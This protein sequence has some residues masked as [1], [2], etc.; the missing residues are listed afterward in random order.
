MSQRMTLGAKLTAGFGAMMLLTLAVSVGAITVISQLGGDMDYA[1][2][3]AGKRNSLAWQM[4]YA[5]TRAMAAERGILLR[6]IV[7]QTAAVDRHKQEFQEASQEIERALGEMQ[8][9]VDDD[10]TRGSVESM[11]TRFQAL[12]QA[13]RELLQAIDRQQFEQVQKISDEK[14]Q[15]RVQEITAEAGALLARQTDAANQA[16]ARAGNRAGGAYWIIGSLIAISGIVAVFLW[17][18][19]RKSS[20][21]LQALAQ[22]MASGASEVA[23]AA[24]QVAEAS[25]SLAQAASEQAATLE[26]TAAS[27]QHL[28]GMTRSN[29]EHAQGATESV[30][31]AD[32]QISGANQTLELM[33]SSMQEI[34]ASSGKISR[35]IKV[36]D[37]I[38]FQTN[39]LALNAA[40]EAARAGEAG[41][42][43]AVVADEVR[44]LAQRCAQAAKDTAELIEDSIEKS[45][46]GQTK[47]SEV[48]QAI[49][50]ITES[51]SSIRTLVDKVN[52][53]SRDQS[54]SI[55]QISTSVNQMQR[56]TQSTAASA[57][58]SAAASQEMSAQADG[59]RNAVDRLH[60]LVG[61][62]ESPALRGSGGRSSGSTPAP[63]SSSRTARTSSKQLDNLRQAVTPRPSNTATADPFPMDEEFREF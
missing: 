27:S 11:R 25:Q 19:V 36:I 55:E 58:Q 48:V 1:V 35:I 52:L 42:G 53:S 21:T 6:S 47:L 2:N 7:Q 9:L 20:V 54:R 24:S 29:L 46:G 34:T 4:N 37:E 10:A 44:N 39:I 49:K 41:M 5:S 50:A 62:S 3:R 8:P 59:M 15:P 33:V 57:E 23:Q 61:G 16:A 13:H 30:A 63:S 56:V 22:E 12:N 40:V 32:R 28:A 26:E 43:F 18:M 45:N 38:A 31:V 14:V 60:Q 51:S 17:F